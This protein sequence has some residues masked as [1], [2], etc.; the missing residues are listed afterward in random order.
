MTLGV[1]ASTTCRSL[2][3]R[4][5][6][7]IPASYQ[8]FTSATKLNI[9]L[10]TR[11]HLYT[12]IGA[13]TPFYDLRLPL[14]HSHRRHHG[15]PVCKV[16]ILLNT[17]SGSILHYSFHASVIS[18]RALGD[19]AIVVARTDSVDPLRASSS[20]SSSGLLTAVA[21]ARQKTRGRAQRHQGH[22]TRCPPRDD[23]FPNSGQ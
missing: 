23:G 10:S 17:A 13:C 16:I 6:D 20:T 4:A 2:S 19:M 15:R 8:C 7:S 9:L 22:S 18:P 21:S 12:F 5:M 1:L 3:Y 11:A 14:G